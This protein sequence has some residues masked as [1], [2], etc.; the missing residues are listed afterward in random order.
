MKRTI[1]SWLIAITIPVLYAVLLRWL[2]DNDLMGQFPI[3][4]MSISFLGG[5]PF[6]VGYLTI[7]LSGIEKVQNK[8]YC[9]MAPWVPI[10]VFM[11][12]TLVWQVEGLAC[13]L[14]ILPIWFGVSTIA[15]LIAGG[16]RRRKHSESQKLQSSWVLLLPL[17]CAPLERLIPHHTVRYEAYTYK[18]IQ[19]PPATIW[20]NVVRV[21]PIG[22]EE[23]RGWLTR[24]LG[25][26]RPIKAELDYAGV[27]GSRQAVFSKGLVFMETVTEYAEQQNMHFT[28]KAD[29]GA[30]P[31][32]AMDKHVVIGGE[33]FD[34][35]DGTY[36]LEKLEN[37]VCRLH[38]YSHFVLKTDFN[39]YASLW[40]GWIMKDIQNNILRVIQTRCQR[41]L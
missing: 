4:L 13:W 32:T 19:A 24:I 29:P 35:L 26:P 2:F 23:E 37:G 39:F 25:F 6:G 36:R 40:A 12:I 22:E 14:M 20:S 11:V 21:R 41:N 33:Y 28:I 9:A 10:V 18:D 16:R 30:I 1:Q 34:V 5:V 27:G 31:P 15:G 38:L 8:K 7:Y 3:A 17:L